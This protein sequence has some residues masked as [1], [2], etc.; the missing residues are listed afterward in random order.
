MKIFF[1]SFFFLLVFHLS[2]SQNGTENPEPEI[3]DSLYREDQFYLGFTFNL[4]NTLP[5]NITQSG[6]S[7]GLHLG[8]MRDMPI[9]EKRNWAIAAGLG[10]SINTYS[11]NLFIGE[12]ENDNT[13]FQSLAEKNIEYDTNRYTMYLVEAPIEI[14]WRTSTPTTYSFWRV[15]AGI[16]FGYIYYFKSNFK[17]PG[18]RV[19]QTKV[20]ELQ[21]FRMGLTLAAGYNK[22]NFYCYYGLNPFFDGEMPNGEEVGMK[23]VKIGLMFYIL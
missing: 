4:L 5:E 2:F 11:A 14:R 3:I 10:W 6:F 15:Y 13:I 1:T 7:G 9:N 18:N 22:V 19:V 17:Q 20:D 23:T 8:F 21:R 12:D 16:K